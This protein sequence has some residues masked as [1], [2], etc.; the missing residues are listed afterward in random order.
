[1]QSQLQNPV[2]KLVSRQASDAPSEATRKSMRANRHAN[3]TP[4]LLARKV[5]W[6]AGFKGYR[7]N[8]AGLP[9]KPDI[10][11]PRYRLCIFIHGCFWHGCEQC[12]QKRNITP[13]QNGEYWAGKVART[14]E[15]D[16]EHLQQLRETGWHV[17]VV[18]ECELRKDAQV[19]VEYVSQFK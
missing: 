9:G 19:I 10:V 18:W 11:F 15:R 17:H 2:K 7:K 16:A 12:G 6:V 5:L 1:M 14:K 13:S 4:E 3:T 8:V